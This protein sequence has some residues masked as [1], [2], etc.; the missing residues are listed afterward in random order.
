MSVWGLNLASFIGF[1]EGFLITLKNA[2]FPGS[3]DWNATLL[4]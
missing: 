2:V 4:S 1:V 3:S